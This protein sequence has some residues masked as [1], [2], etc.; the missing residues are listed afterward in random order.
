MTF[1]LKRN[2]TVPDGIRRIV[3]ERI[4]RA[5]HILEK[6]K[7]VRDRAVHEAR[8]RFKEVRGVLRL[9][10]PELGERQFRRENRAFRDAGR[11][12]SN[13]RDAKALLDSL[14][15]LAAHYGITPTSHSFVRLRSALA[16]RRR[17][18]RQRVFKKDRATTSIVR[19]VRKSS[20]RVRK[21]PLHRKGW[22]AIAIGLEKT[23]GKC[24]ETMHTALRNNGDESLHEW[25]KCT[26]NLRYEI[27]VLARV[28]PNVMEPIAETSHR[29][30]DLLGK[31]HDLAVLQQFVENELPSTDG[32]GERELLKPLVERRRKELQKEGREL[33]QKLFAENK[34]EFVHR[35]H[36][37]WKAWG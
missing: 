11:P 29:L 23:Y 16:A 8:K 3:F 13:V 28:F 5:L 31:D 12:L 36:G 30:T 37:Y 19:K 25:R 4:D 20:R 32:D 10:R 26:K 22:K 15:D 34:R 1:E 17:D 2:E 7:T 35:I 27:E 6:R 24:R 18:V 14:D 21:W 33:G 9:V